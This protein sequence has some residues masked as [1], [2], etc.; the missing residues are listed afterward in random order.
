MEVP[1]RAVHV[2]RVGAAVPSACMVY[3]SSCRRWVT[4]TLGAVSSYTCVVWGRWRV[5]VI[6]VASSLRVVVWQ[7]M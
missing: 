3:R 2:Y 1:N 6:L 4:R 5:T 7:M